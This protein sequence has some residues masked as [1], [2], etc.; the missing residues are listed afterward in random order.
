[1]QTDLMNTED[2]V[3]NRVWEM[4][5]EINETERHFNNLETKY[6]IL[7]S[8]W[9]LGSF[10]GI[11]FVLTEKTDLPFDSLWIAI[12]ICLVSSVG[13]FQLWRMDLTIYQQLLRAAFFEGIKMEN[14][15][16]FLPKIKHTMQASV[17]GGD[18][19]KTLVYYYSGSISILLIVATVVFLILKYSALDGVRI[20]LFLVCVIALI[21]IMNFYMFKKSSEKRFSKT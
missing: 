6:R 19:T 8:Q 1:M 16:P 7:A 5:K 10:A 13:I 3:F 4:I 20:I 18:V 21:V 14:E 9:L 15:F 12:G 17:K 2:K 11:G